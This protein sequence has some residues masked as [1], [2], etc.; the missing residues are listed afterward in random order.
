MERLITLYGSNGFS[1]GDALTWADLAIFDVTSALFS[2]HPDLSKN[3][4]KLSAVDEKIKNH[5]N[6]AKYI[7]A[8]PET[9][10]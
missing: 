8:R 3:Y 6:I 10:F 7:A 4:P 9:P 5:P 2:K 1:V